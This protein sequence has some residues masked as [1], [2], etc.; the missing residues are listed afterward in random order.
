[1]F[2]TSLTCTSSFSAQ[3]TAGNTNQVFVTTDVDCSETNCGIPDTYTT[4]VTLTATSFA[5]HATTSCAE[6]NC[7]IPDDFTSSAIPS[8]TQVV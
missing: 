7:G 6:T 5:A 4:S 3:C 1:L 2:F 8:A